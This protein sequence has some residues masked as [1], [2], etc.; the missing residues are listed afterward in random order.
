MKDYIEHQ[1]I[2]NPFAGIQEYP[3]RPSPSA[4]AM[5]PKTTPGKRKCTETKYKI[6]KL[7]K[8]RK[9][10]KG[11]SQRF[12]YNGFAPVKIAETTSQNPILTQPAVVAVPMQ[13][14]ATTVTYIQPITIPATA[15]TQLIVTVAG[16]PKMFPK[17]CALCTPIGRQCPNNYLLPIHTNWSDPEKEENKQEEG[18][19]I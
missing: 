12:Q 19:E 1:N 5:K 16:Q 10:D 3:N 17:F 9:A 2:N 7:C 15:P 14:M 11:H 6:R 8:L 13:Q 18:E 4:F